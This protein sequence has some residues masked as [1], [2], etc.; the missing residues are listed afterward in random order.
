ML[1][2][3]G[4][5]RDGGQATTA[6]LEEAR[7]T[8]RAIGRTFWLA[9]RLLAR[10]IR[11]DVHLLYLVLRTLDDVVDE[12]RAEADE[13]VGAVESWA[14]GG[15]ATSREARILEAIEARHGIERSVVDDFCAGMRDDLSRR[16]IQTEADL[17]EYCYRVAGTVG[18]L[19][20]SL[21]GSDDPAAARRP[22]IALG[23]AMQRTNILRDIDED[24]GNDRCT[25]PARRSSAS[26]RRLPASAPSCSATRSLA[27]TR[28]T[29]RASPGSRTCAAAAWPSLRPP[30]CTAR[31]CGR[32]SARASA[33]APAGPW[34][35]C[36]ARSVPRRVRSSTCERARGSRS[37]RDAARRRAPRVASRPCVPHPSSVRPSR[38]ARS[39][40]GSMRRGRRG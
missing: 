20:T 40:T 32:S 37:P 14:R 10:D 38:P 1:M 26:A 4:T 5:S 34:C 22:A 2:G 11:D 30:A 28:S 24:A 8:H 6:L 31:S 13:V 33:S 7:A 35:R 16:I 36:G 15:A 39:P 19:M 9:S 25:W 3:S 29:T 12:R 18:L 21:L 17:D 27:P 23:Q